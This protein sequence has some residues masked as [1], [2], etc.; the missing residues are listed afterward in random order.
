MYF[1]IGLK[2]W[3]RVLQNVKLPPAQGRFRRVGERACHPAVFYG[4]L[5]S[6]KTMKKIALTALRQ[7]RSIAPR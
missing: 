4:T 1:F 3:D 5:P 2:F 6:M 7:S